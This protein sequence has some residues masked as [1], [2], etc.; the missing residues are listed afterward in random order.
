MPCLTTVANE[1]DVEMVKL[2]PSII[3]CFRP[4]ANIFF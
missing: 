2:P 4:K 3:V 1:R